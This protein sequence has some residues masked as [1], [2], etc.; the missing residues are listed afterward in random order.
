M[1][2][3]VKGTDPKLAQLTASQDE[4]DTRIKKKPSDSST[5]I[6]P[7]QDQKQQQQQR[8]Q[9]AQHLYTRRTAL[10]VSHD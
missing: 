5:D 7:G 6:Q 1:S 9:Q 10:P 8:P 3:W 4:N 2:T